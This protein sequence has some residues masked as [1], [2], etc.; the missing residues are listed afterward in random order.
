[1]HTASGVN[2]LGLDTTFAN[3]SQH[4]ARLLIKNNLFDDVNG[5]KWNGEGKLFQLL[6]GTIDVVIDHNTAFHTSNV[7]TAGGLPDTGFVFTNN[8][9][10]H[11][12]YGVI[13]DNV[14]SGL[15]T[16]TA[17]FPGAV[18]AGNILVGVPAGLYP[19][20][21]YFPSTLDA[22][23]FVDFGGGDYHLDA[24]SPYKSAGTDGQDVGLNVDALNAAHSQ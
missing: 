2:I 12:L 16:L 14:G 13:G 23:G 19:A 10:Q 21:N 17:Y 22:I 7:I 18:F 6:N 15:A 5:A 24:T 8:I 11:N 1:Q 4:T 9:T 3:G 20:G